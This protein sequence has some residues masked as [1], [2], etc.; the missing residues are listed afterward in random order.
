MMLFHCVLCC[1]EILSAITFITQGFFTKL[2]GLSS[3]CSYCTAVR[4]ERPSL[5]CNTADRFWWLKQHNSINITKLIYNNKKRCLWN[6]MP[7][8]CV[9]LVNRSRVK[10]HKLW[11][12]LEVLE[13]RNKHSKDQTFNLSVRSIWQSESTQPAELCALWHLSV[14]VRYLNI[15]NAGLV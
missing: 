13:Q 6:T 4:L 12:H 3:N 14:L 5:F 9:N 7:L 1:L 15:S 8:L 2:P 11:G 10:G